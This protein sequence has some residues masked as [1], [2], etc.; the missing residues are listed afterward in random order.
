MTTNFKNLN[1]HR[2]QDK[3]T[4]EFQ[5]LEHWFTQVELLFSQTIFI[6]LLKI[7]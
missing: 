7:A 5:K 4:V 3:I 1:K 2:V 6:A